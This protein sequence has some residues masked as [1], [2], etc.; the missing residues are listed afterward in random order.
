MMFLPIFVMLVTGLL[1]VTPLFLPKLQPRKN[2]PYMIAQSI[3][4]VITYLGLIGALFKP[5][6]NTS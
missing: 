1:M 4:I 2:K 6:E 5:G 3:V